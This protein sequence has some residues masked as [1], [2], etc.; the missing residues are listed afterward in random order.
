[1]TQPFYDRLRVYYTKVGSVLR[2]EADGASIFPNT[3][4]IGMSR[5]KV[6]AEFLKMHLPSSCNV[7]LG[8]F[9][10]NLDGQESEQIDIIVTNDVSPRFNFYNP[11]GQGKAFSCIEG[12]IAVVSVKSTLDSKELRDALEN[13][14]SIPCKRVLGSRVNFLLNTPDYDDW[15]FKIIYASD[16]V[17]AGTTLETLEDFYK[18]SHHVEYWRRPNLIHIAGKYNVVRVGKNGGRL[19]DGTP[20]AAN[21]FCPNFD[22][23]D[24]HALSYAVLNIQQNAMLSSHIL[25]SYWELFD[26]IPLG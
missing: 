12:C 22:P 24:V 21:T 4:D 11:D 2:G 20:L 17:S 19:R 9:L 5:E 16:G 25:F 23:T 13:L 14:A 15:P 8:G 3:T 10:F 18:S 7:S 1:M 26:N 6:Y